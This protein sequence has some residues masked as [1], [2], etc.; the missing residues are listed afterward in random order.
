M[1][2][3]YLVVPVLLVV[4][5]VGAM[6]K[7]YSVPSNRSQ[8]SRAFGSRRAV[9]VS[10]AIALAL[11]VIDAVNG[12]VTAVLGGLVPALG[13]GFVVVALARLV[14]GVRKRI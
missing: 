4:A 12:G 8:L 3:Q 7:K 10:V 6:A 9:A 11:V 14:P 1:H 13:I 5:G 2:Y